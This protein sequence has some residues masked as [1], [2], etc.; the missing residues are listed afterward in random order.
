MLCSTDFYADFCSPCYDLDFE[1]SYNRA[2]LASA[3]PGKSYQVLVQDTDDRSA[4]SI[5]AIATRSED[6]DLLYVVVKTPA[7]KQCHSWNWAL[8]RPGFSG[9][10][11]V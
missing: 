10:C 5:H 2:I 8:N 6:G 3:K 11:L 7:G 4:P 9:G 1:N